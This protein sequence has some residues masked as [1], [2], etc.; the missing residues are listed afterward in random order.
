MELGLI[1]AL[2]MKTSLQAVRGW[3]KPI[4]NDL[5]MFKF[6]VTK[7]WHPR[8]LSSDRKVLF[9]YNAFVYKVS[10]LEDSIILLKVFDNLCL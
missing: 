6:G 2:T 3:E 10:S 9:W 7:A 5:C 4:V 1:A 8:D